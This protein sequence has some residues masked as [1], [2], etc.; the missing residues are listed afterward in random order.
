MA[1]RD[2]QLRDA[3]QWVAVIINKRGRKRK[4][5]Y[6]SSINTQRNA[7]KERW[8][9]NAFDKL[10]WRWRFRSTQSNDR[11]RKRGDRRWERVASRLK[12]KMRKNKRETSVVG[13]AD[14]GSGCKASIRRD[15]RQINFTKHTPH[16]YQQQ[17]RWNAKQF[18]WIFSG[19]RERLERI[20]KM[21]SY[22]PKSQ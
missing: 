9:I 11:W 22:I 20:A 18:R 5:A 6:P 3:S 14:E 13:I 10:H 19:F 12:R 2:S 17:V 8:S 15:L 7:S 4:Q 1:Q 16:L 21:I